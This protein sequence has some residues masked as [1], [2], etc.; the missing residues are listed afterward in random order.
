MPEI[1]LEVSLGV[2]GEFPEAAQDPQNLSEVCET[3]SDHTA[4]T[5]ESA[6]RL[7]EGCVMLMSEMQ[8]THPD[9]LRGIRVSRVL[10]SSVCAWMRGNLEQ[11]QELSQVTTQLDEFWSHSWQARLWLKYLYPPLGTTFCFCSCTTQEDIK[12]YYFY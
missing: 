6:D 7:I 10:H 9:I 1:S 5:E 2:P 3:V 4:S 11:I 12:R 8:P